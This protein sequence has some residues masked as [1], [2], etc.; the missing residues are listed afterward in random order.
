M[1]LLLPARPSGLRSPCPARARVLGFPRAAAIQ[2][3][4]VEKLATPLSG[5]AERYRIGAAI[6][7]ACH[8]ESFRV[9]SEPCPSS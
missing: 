1:L 4:A 5:F 7:R 3:A 6:M 9:V 8:E 2:K